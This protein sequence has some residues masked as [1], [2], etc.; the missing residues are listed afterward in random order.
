[1]NT[2]KQSS[3]TIIGAGLAGTFFAILLAKRGMKVEV[4]ER[5]SRE[6]I[7]DNASKRSYTLTM[8]GYGIQAIHDAGLWE[9]VKPLFTVLA[10]SM[11]QVN[12][13]TKPIIVRLG[14]KLPFYCVS[15]AKLLGALVKHA[16]QQPLITFHFNTTFIAADRREKTI[17]VQQKDNTYKTISCDVIFGADGVNSQIRHF[18]QQGQHTTHIQEIED[19]NYKQIL[20]SKEI[21]EKMHLANDLSNA[22]TRKNAIFVAYP[23]GDGSFSGM[24][25]LPKKEHLGFAELTST[26]AIKD[27]FTKQYPEF[28]VG[29][30][31]ITKI[32]LENPVGWLGTIYTTPWY[33]QDFM[34]L[35]GDAAHGFLPFYG[36]GVS[37][38]FG[39]CLTLAELVD[40]YGDDWATIFPIFE[41]KRKRNTDTLANLSKESFVQ[42]RRHKKADY[43]AIYNKIDSVLYGAF[44]KFF[45]PPAFTRIAKDQ[46]HAADYFAKHQEQRKRSKMLGIPLIVLTL[47]GLV[48][49]YEEG[50]NFFKNRK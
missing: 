40:T 35:L 38:S 28:L 49:L 5:F 44:P 29:L 19:W 4:Y 2:T 42:Y 23:N 20:I 7:D 12:S 8:Y 18:L 14:T 24:L 45:H 46:A 15:R 34:A 6:E 25:L 9:V 21:A 30:P 48:A 47:T 33:Y 17:T 39:D 31:E 13:H 41:E 26:S 27:F 1:M 22:W 32:I 43:A 3:I 36:Q 37:A 10:G 16:E 50:S 11:T